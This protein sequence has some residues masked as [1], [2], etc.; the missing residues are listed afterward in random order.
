[1][2]CTREYASAAARG[3]MLAGLK[4]PKPGLSIINTPISPTKTAIQLRIPTFSPIRNTESN[5]ISNGAIKK[6]ATASASGIVT[7][8]VKK[9]RLA[10]T[11]PNPL[12]R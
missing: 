6:I 11:I 9:Q 8:D 1:M 5:V 7:N 12:K 10:T 4:T 3:S 2:I